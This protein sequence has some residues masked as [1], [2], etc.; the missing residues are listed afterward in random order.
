VQELRGQRVTVCGLGLFGGGA[1]CVRWLVERGAR[2]TVTDLRSVA[3]LEPSVAALRDLD[4]RFVLGRHD[5]SDFAASDLV[6]ANPAVPPSSPFL[7]VARSAGVPITSEIALGLAAT[8]ASWIGVT[9]T[10]GKSSTTAFAERACRSLA[11][12]VQLAGNLGGS[13]VD[14]VARL[15][16]GDLVVLELSSY[17]LEA[18]ETDALRKELPRARAVCVTNVDRDHLDRHGDLERYTEVK[19]SIVGWAAPNAPVFLPARGRA[20][21]LA[22]GGRPRVTFTDLDEPADLRIAHDCFVDGDVELGRVA[23]LAPR[24]RFQRRNALVALGIAHR[25]GAEPAELAR[26]VRTFAA[27]PHRL[28]RLAD[29]DGHAVWDNGVSTTPASTLA[30]LE[31]LEPPCVV[32][33]GGRDKELAWTELA[34]ALARRGDRVVAFGEARE[35]IT[36]ELARACV[37]VAGEASLD[38]AVVLACDWRGPDESLLFSPACASFDAYPNFAERARAFRT[39]LRACRERR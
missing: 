20:S 16:T 6:V 18:L 31:S 4:V 28:E 25:L 22:T 19:G 37:P 11:P 21:E 13:L 35:H 17:Q 33:C 15:A 3:A 36:T 23:D 9:G 30:A 24:G 32:L 7:A 27:P 34:E 5:E 38:A 12:R 26:A 2:V 1:G 10:H 29:V 39:A 14:R 8:R